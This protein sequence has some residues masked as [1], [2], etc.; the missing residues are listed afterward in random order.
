MTVTIQVDYVN[1]PLIVVSLWGSSCMKKINN[2]V[3]VKIITQNTFSLITPSL[4][5]HR[6]D[7]LAYMYIF[8]R[9]DTCIC[10]RN[11]YFTRA[12]R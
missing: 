6:V 5:C 7:V 3:V 10:L 8:I 1:R 4:P 2:K 9:G 12:N 11:C